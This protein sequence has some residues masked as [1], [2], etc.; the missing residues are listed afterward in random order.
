VI[1][2]A[3]EK[4]GETIKRAIMIWDAKRSTPHLAYFGAFFFIQRHG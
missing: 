4:L 2:L 3:A 1:S